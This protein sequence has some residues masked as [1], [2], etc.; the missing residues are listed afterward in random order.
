MIVDRQ[1]I[2]TLYQMGA[3]DDFRYLQQIEQRV[4]DAE[5]RVTNSQRTLVEQ[6]SKELAST[7]RTPEQEDWCGRDAPEGVH[8]DS[9]KDS[10]E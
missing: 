1:Y 9:Y 2:F 5:A 8:R 3:G 7:K 10:Y 4:E 6:L